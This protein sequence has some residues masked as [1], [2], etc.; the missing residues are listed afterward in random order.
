MDT[1]QRNKS[2]SAGRQTQKRRASGR[3]GA[4]RTRSGSAS[5]RSSAAAPQRKQQSRTAR[6]RRSA[7]SSRQRVSSQSRQHTATRNRRERPVEK[8]EVVYTPAKPFNRNR[9]LLQLL[10]VAAVVVALVLGLSIFFKVK[11]ITVSGAE[12]Y[13]AWTIREASGIK[14][15]ENLLTF[16]QAKAS[17]KI[18]TSLPY[19]KDVQI[20]IK[21]P[22][23][24]HI[25]ITELDVVYAIQ[26]GD[27]SWWLITA[28]GK[29]V[30]QVDEATAGENT[31]I[32]GVKL[33]SPEV[34]GQASAMSPAQAETPTESASES[35]PTEVST[36]P[37]VSVTG[38]EQLAVALKIVQAL[39]EN[40]VFGKIA[41]VD[42]TDPGALELWY[43][44]RYQIELGD[45]ENLDVKIQW[46]AK[47]VSQLA[48]HESGVIDVSFTTWED[49]AGY[50]PFP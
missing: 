25:E 26:A 45:S 2:A 4:E 30:E 17:G 16:G 31:A 39:E 32:I 35:Q 49:Q 19:V 27:N 28:G 44:D 14:E 23:T 33:A 1:K 10:T 46:M 11:Y 38:A 43:G 6:Q 34:Q 41:T 20:G 8:Q 7:A 50:T 47:T 22:D 42:V 5:S 15:G 36:A 12:K 48:A 13:D 37:D 40:G 18:T 24:V 3:N 9:L 29:V 21:L